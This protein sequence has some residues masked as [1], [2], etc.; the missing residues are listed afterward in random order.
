MNHEKDFIDESIK[1]M[2]FVYRIYR[3]CRQYIMKNRISIKVAEIKNYQEIFQSRCVDFNCKR[4]LFHELEIQD[5]RDKY[6]QL[7]IMRKLIN[8]I[9]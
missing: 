8:F 6:H 2:S 9:V 1:N 3:I 4:I 7:T 5:V